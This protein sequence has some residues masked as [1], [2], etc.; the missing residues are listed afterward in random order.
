MIAYS[1]YKALK[2]NNKKHDAKEGGDSNSTKGSKSS[3]SDQAVSRDEYED[4]MTS[5]KSN[6]PFADYEDGGSKAVVKQ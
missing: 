4:A 1:I 6:N 5:D 2:K 3:S